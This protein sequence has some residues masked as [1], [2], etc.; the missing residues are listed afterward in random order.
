MDPSRSVISS[1]LAIFG[2]SE[3]VKESP[4]GAEVVLQVIN[5]L[6]GQVEL[7]PELGKIILA[8]IEKNAT[9]AHQDPM[10]FFSFGLLLAI[11]RLKRYQD[12]FLRICTGIL[13]KERVLY[14][15]VPPIFSSKIILTENS[16]N[17]SKFVKK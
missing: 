2:T 10:G 12:Q 9:Y 16:R 4:F 3:V 8:Q 17:S 13:L 1:L 11:T 5:T 14:A 7:A 15:T 6:R